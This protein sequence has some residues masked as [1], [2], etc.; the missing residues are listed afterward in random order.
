VVEA[1]GVELIQ[2]I[3]NKQVV[4]SAIP[5]IPPIPPVLARF[6]TVAGLVGQLRNRSLPH[7]YDEAPLFTHLNVAPP[8]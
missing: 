1:G 3:E 6:G 4:D 8:W 2:A 7:G 5:P